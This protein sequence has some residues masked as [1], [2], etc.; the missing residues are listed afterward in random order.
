MNDL[1]ILIDGSL[2]EG[3]GQV[4]RTSLTLSAVTGRP[5]RLR[6]IRK[7]RANPGLQRQHLTAVR[8]AAAICDAAVT[9]DAL[10]STDLDFRPG[11]LRGADYR[12]DIG[13]AGSATLVLQT[14]L[15]ALACAPEPSSVLIEG[16]THNPL[17]PPFEFLERAWLPWLRAMGPKVTLK[18]DRVGFYPVGGGKVRAAIEPADRLTP[19]RIDERGPL[20]ELSAE[21]IVLGL[22]ESIAQRELSVLRRALRI[23]ENRLR[24]VTPP[25]SG[26]GN[27]VG[28]TARCEHITEHFS[29]I[30]AK[31]VP[32]ERVAEQAAA[33]A[34]AWL[35]AG[36]PVG[37]HLCD[38][39]LVLLA[40]AGEGTFL[41]GPLTGHSTTNLMTI[42]NFASCQIE[43]TPTEENAV[44]VTATRGAI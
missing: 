35:S 37:P 33:E 26:M 10:H 13:T 19:L 8:A 1:G 34:Q 40:L 43:T 3:G 6:N 17:A 30:G 41:T 18:L 27:A 4:L 29:A 32:A 16:G 12:F 20:R 5:F 15:P 36:A 7:N 39:L 21:A 42:S 11:R 28:I 24:T 31:G 38:Q 9:G 44:R 2:G 22:P 14:I 25:G 23:P